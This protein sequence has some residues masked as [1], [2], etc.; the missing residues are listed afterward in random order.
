MSS[1]PE[2]GSEQS[3]WTGEAKQKFATYAA[4]ID[5]N[6]LQKTKS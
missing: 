2:E 1:K 5:T 3:P 6:L 4:S